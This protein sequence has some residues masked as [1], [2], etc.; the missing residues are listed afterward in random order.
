MHP[1]F[2]AEKCGIR[3][4]ESAENRRKIGRKPTK[5]D[6]KFDG[7]PTE[8]RRKTAAAAGQLPQAR[9]ASGT[10]TIRAFPVYEGILVPKMTK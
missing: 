10:D 7:K 8:N 1:P 6:R 2:Y 5:T 9:H 4:H 3:P